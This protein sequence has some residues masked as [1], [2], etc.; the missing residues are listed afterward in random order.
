MDK[1]IYTH[2]LFTYDGRFETA[3]YEIVTEPTPCII[4]R[5]NGK[6]IGVAFLDGENIKNA[7]NGMVKKEM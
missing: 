1:K 2:R 3:T 4:K 5:I 7:Y 6:D